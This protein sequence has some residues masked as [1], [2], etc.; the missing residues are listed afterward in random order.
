MG[1][2]ASLHQFTLDYASLHQF[3][4]DDVIMRVS[5]LKKKEYFSFN[6][7][8]IHIFKSIYFQAHANNHLNKFQGVKDF[9]FF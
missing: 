8:F 3:M 6:K 7:T 1:A 4:L 9:Y 5:R 2:S